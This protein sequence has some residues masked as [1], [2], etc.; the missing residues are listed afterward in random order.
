VPAELE[1]D[2]GFLQQRLALYGSTVAALSS[3]FLGTAWLTHFA[4]DREYLSDPGRIPHVI[5]T[6]IAFVIWLVARRRRV[7]SIGVLNWLDGVGTVA[8]GVMFAW[9]AYELPVGVGA[10]VGFLATA[11]VALGR[12]AQL[13]S[14]PSRTFVISALSFGAVMVAAVLGPL[15][16]G[17]PSN[18]VGRAFSVIDPLLWTVSG[19]ALATL[20]S[21]VI[22]GLQE[23]VYEAR[24]LGQ[25]T[26]E[27]KI[28]QG[29]MG[30][31]FRASHA[32]LRRPTAIKLLPGEHSESQLRR[33]E[34]EVRLTASLTHPNTISIF[35]FGRTPEGTFYYA[36][37]LLRGLSLEALIERHGAQPPGRVVKI[38]LQ[39]CGALSEAHGVGLIHRDIKPANVFL[40]RLGGIDDFVKVLDFGLVRQITEDVSLSQS[41]I[42]HLVGTP[43]YM[44]PESI[45]SP[46]KITSQAD[47]YSLGAT[48][49][50]L[51]TGT[52]PF[53]GGSVLEVCGHHLHTAPEGLSQRLGRPVPEALERI[54][55]ACLSKEPS[56]R[57][58]G[59]KAL[60]GLLE[61]AGG[62][63]D[64]TAEEA[65]RFWEN[66]QQTGERHERAISGQTLHIA[67]S[68]RGLERGRDFPKSA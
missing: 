61:A 58:A 53:S 13:P 24:Q 38:L 37:E 14:T 33:F 67:L 26:L 20:A 22:Y 1:G 3:L 27:A 23:K 48:A 50:H 41:S 60:A 52:P 30:E 36:M 49:Y 34:R 19:T 10:L 8:M 12:A 64:Y 40:C 6:G 62:V 63:P 59:A 21:R 17:Y 4:V 29:G 54:V 11:Y 46:D 18:T 2:L 28:G 35:D 56:A 15:P 39:A 68:D 55:L 42:Q 47:L 25:Y 51:L 66:E 45:I 43:L 31:I 9:M 7:L 65:Q 5:A 16:P 44:P 32:M 57:P